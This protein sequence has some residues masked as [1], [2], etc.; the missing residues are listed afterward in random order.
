MSY[1]LKTIEEERIKHET[2]ILLHTVTLKE[3]FQYEYR[4]KTKDNTSRELAETRLV[5]G[6]LLFTNNTLETR[7][8]K[9]RALV[10][11]VGNRAQKD[12]A[13]KWDAGIVEGG[14]GEKDDYIRVQ[15]VKI[16]DAETA[17]RDIGAVVEVKKT[18]V[19]LT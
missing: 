2:G 7:S 12:D 15:R 17:N 18:D 9:E 1:H 16:G 8:V 13:R 4:Y 3:V 14:V 10:I 6:K 19:R 11:F 5:D